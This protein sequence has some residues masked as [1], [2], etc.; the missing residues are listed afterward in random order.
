VTTAIDT[1]VI[2]SLWSGDDQLNQSARTAIEAAAGNGA[3]AMSTPVFA[4]LM[5]APGITED[6]VAEFCARKRIV[7]EWQIPENVWR[8]AGRAYRANA[9]R[10][11]HSGDPHPRRIL[12]DFLIGA[13][14]LANG[15]ALLT[16]DKSV[17]RAAFPAL[18]LLTF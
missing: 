18:K 9:R 10:R 14:A 7:V 3:L 5:A 6:F 17:Y 4:E 16:M 2:A 1:N 15:Y 11:R 12:A 8:E 13:H